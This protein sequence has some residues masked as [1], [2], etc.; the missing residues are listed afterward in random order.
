[1]GA[2]LAAMLAATRARWPNLRF[3]VQGG[4]Q[5]RLLQYLKQDE[6]DLVVA[7]VTDEPEGSARHY[8][9]EELAWVRGKTTTLD[10]SAPIPLVGYKDRCMCHR[11][12]L[13]TL[14]KAGMA[15]ELVFRATNA[16]ALRSAVSR[17]PRRHAGAA[18]PHPGRARSLG[19][20]PVAAAA[21]GVLR[22][23]R[24]RGRGER[25]ARSARGPL[26][27]NA[28]PARGRIRRR[29]IRRPPGS[30]GAGRAALGLKSIAFAFGLT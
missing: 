21:R 6:L 24:A 25:H 20:R 22:H 12:A 3:A 10:L 19:R 11:V 13:A 2:E 15:G 5:R 18:Q 1:M 28:A 7:L 16:E 30:G 8:W 23:L 14:A 26:C 17:R 4:G 9:T 27:G 29:G